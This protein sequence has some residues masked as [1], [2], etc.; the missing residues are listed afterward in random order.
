[1]II[2]TKEQ[3]V[4]KNIG[5]TTDSI[6]ASINTSSMPFLFEMLSESLYSNPIGS[7]CREITSNCFDSHIEAKV[8]DPVTIR[9]SIDEEGYYISF[10]D[11]GMG[12]DPIR[13]QNIYMNYFSSTKRESNDLIGGFGLGSKSPLAY[14]DYFYIN[15]IFDFIKYQ[16]IFSK[17]TTIPTLDLLDKSEVSERN[18]TEIRIYIKDLYDVNKF[19]DELK[20][21]LCYF[22]NVYF[23]GW[24]IDN[25]YNIFEGEYFKY[26]NKN[27]Y[28]SKMHIVLD[29]VVYPI[30]WK[31]L[32]IPEYNI[33]VGI[34]FKIGELLVTPNREQIRYTD[35][36]ILLIKD[37]INKTINEL[38][39]IF[40]KQNKS[41]DSYFDW[42]INKN[43]KP[44]ISFTNENEEINKLYLHGLDHANKK[45]NYKYFEGID[46]IKDK[47]DIL[48]LFYTCIGE[49]SKGKKKKEFYINGINNL[50]QYDY[51]KT[52]I[53]NTTYTN[54]EKDWLVKNGYI[55]YSK[56]NK[57][58]IK[59][60]FLIASKNTNTNIFNKYYFNLGAGLRIYK[61][62]KAI[63]KEVN[64][65][66]SKYRD[67]T[68]SELIEYK[69]EKR[70]N[71]NAIQRKLNGK[72]LV[73]SLLKNVSYE[74]ELR[75]TLK[76]RYYTRG[77][78]EFKGIVIYG[79]KEDDVKLKKAITLISNVR[80]KYFNYNGNIINNNIIEVIKISKQNNKYFKNKNNM[81]HVDNLY[82]TKLFRD[83]AS[84]FKIEQYFNDIENNNNQNMKDYI[85]SMKLICSDIGNTLDELY[86]F[87]INTNNNNI[88]TFS[89]TRNSI[90]LEIIN[91]AETYNLYNPNVEL[92]FNKINNWFKDVELIRYININDKTLPYIL[93]TL[94]DN[95]KRLNIEYYQKIMHKDENKQLSLDFDKIVINA[96][97]KFNFITQ[98]V[99]S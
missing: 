47:Y 38:I 59:S 17:G 83:M 76:D 37:R 26:R 60:L 57:S 8:D 80:P 10:I 3:L 67:L 98:N 53:S 28:D 97:T 12:L 65:K 11:V 29:K 93:K 79:F 62:I 68:E 51:H 58:D 85:K 82:K 23:E 14:T 61:L 22:D 18:G 13:I 40:D 46:D 87:Y 94:Y 15:T 92:L 66:C 7:I 33:A 90:R 75:K 73:T 78:D 44:Y 9:K 45:I 81:F 52:Y 72:V 16:Y 89:Y 6:E 4:I 35:D 34:K 43:Q 1:M 31:Q 27:Q 25:N 91:I 63:R 56:L 64:N 30:D 2:E 86:K 71:N 24:G 20:K 55:I 50:L 96:P 54:I 41:F 77:I 39:T 5:V 88:Y 32:K 49:I 69:E 36:I 42:L 70:S 99:M 74:W 84:S 48:S 95:K 19:E 21:Q